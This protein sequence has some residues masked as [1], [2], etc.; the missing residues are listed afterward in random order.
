[1]PSLTFLGAARTVTG[2]KHLLDV[3]GQRIL[4]DCGLFQGLKELRLRNWSPLPIFPETINAVVLTH[5]HI[6]H[7]GWLPR[8]VSQGL[9]GPVY[10][11][12]GTLDLCRLV[13]PD[14]AHLQEEDAKFANKRGF[15]KHQPALPLYTEEDAAEALSRFKV[16]DYGKKIE[17]VKGIEI[18]FINAGHLLGSSYVLVTRSDK[19]GGR[20]LFGGDL[21]RYARPIL[22][23]PS[24]GVAAD[25][26]L[27]ESTYGDRLHPAE[28]NGETLARIIKETFARRGKVIVPAFAIGRVEE[29]LYWL[30]RLEDEGRLEKVPI[31][32]DS[33]MAIKGIAFYD[34]RTDELDKEIVS[35]RRKLPRFTSVNSA[36]ESKALVERDAPAV[37]IASSGMATGGRVVH[38]LFAG[39][40]DPRNTV[41]FVG[42]QAAGTRGRQL[43]DGAQYVKMFGQQV[44]VH[45]K[46]EK[47]DGM[48]SHADA[49]EIVRWLRT[50]PRAPKATYLVHG[51][52]V[53]QDALKVRIT[54]ELG[55]NVEIPW[56]GQKVDLPL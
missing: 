48:S 33:P 34:A 42:F 7:S 17:V 3:D 32:V 10:C 41:L 35:M 51:E 23:D 53:A 16:V 45:A 20:I 5:A 24:P 46:I 30:F 21:G 39:L 19:S 1:M 31:Y 43:V 12:G 11:T 44:P 9:K 49:G 14:A 25:V 28:D 47:I 13:L 38:H 56:H 29:L 26:L 40:P 8:L 18:E 15:S 37:I 36:L 6:D 2:S 50:F 55:W 4:F 52:P 54:K 27:V 22:P